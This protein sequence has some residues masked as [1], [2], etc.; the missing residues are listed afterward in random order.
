MADLDDLAGVDRV[1]LDRSQEFDGPGGGRGQGRGAGLD[2]D[3]RV[4]DGG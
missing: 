2:G 3:Q 1:A 4:V